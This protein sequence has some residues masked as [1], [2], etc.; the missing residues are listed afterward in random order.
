[1]TLP[2][3]RRRRS[4]VPALLGAQLASAGRVFR[5]PRQTARMA[6]WPHWEAPRRVVAAGD[7]ERRR[8]ASARR[9]P[10]GGRPARAARRGALPRLRRSA[11]SRCGAARAR[12]G[13][14]RAGPPRRPRSRPTAMPTSTTMRLARFAAAVLRRLRRDAQAGRGV[15][16]RERAAGPR[17]TR[18]RRAAGGR[19]PTRRR[20]VADGV[21][22]LPF[23]AHART[24]PACRWRSSTAAGRA[25]TASPHSGSKA[26]AVRSCRR[27]WRRHLRSCRSAPGR[28]LSQGS[29]SARP[30][31]RTVSGR[32]RVRS[33]KSKRRRAGRNPPCACFVS[34]CQA[35][36]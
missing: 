25:P 15:L 2:G 31:F 26:T 17:R 36:G 19:C 6:H 18:A 8:S 5:G 32:A 33:Y 34:G 14:I 27:R 29:S 21:F 7:P 23:R 24:R 9:Q 30:D 3:I 10:R 12:R 20:L 4:G 11:A 22:R 16:R 1:M 35:A 13:R 28:D